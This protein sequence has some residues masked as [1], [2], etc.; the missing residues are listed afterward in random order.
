M[1]S[2]KQKGMTLIEMVL[3]LVIGTG[4]IAGGVG[5]YNSASSS[6]A[7][8][9]LVGGIASIQSGARA[10][11]A[12]T[13]NFGAGSLNGALIRNNKIP[14]ALKPSVAN[15]FTPAGQTITVNG[16]TAN[17]TITVTSATPTECT[18]LITNSGS[19]LSYKVGGGATVTAVP[20]D[21]VA[22][23][24][25]CGAAATVILTSN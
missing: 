24:A 5:Y 25:A 23:D 10:L 1:K 9:D 14:P 12:G 13:G 20:A 16:A 18:T 19:F 6:A 21:P 3:V 2:T 11:A 17:F 15:I 4:I 8:K 22:A 7:S